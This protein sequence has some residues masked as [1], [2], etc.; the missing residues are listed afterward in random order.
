MFACAVGLGGATPLA[1]QT[2]SADVAIAK[3]G[4]LAADA[5][6][7]LVFQ[8]QATNLGPGVARGVV[9]Q[10]Q[11]PPELLFLSA[12]G[13]ATHSAGLVTWP[14]VDTLASGA[15]TTVFTVRVLALN[16]TPDRRVVNN[17]GL[18]STTTNDP[19]ASNDVVDVP[20]VV[21]GQLQIPPD[22]QVTLIAPDSVFSGDVFQYVIEVFNAGPG[23]E[24][25]VQVSHLLPAS[26]TLLGTTP[27]ATRN[28]NTLRWPQIDSIVAGDRRTFVIDVR[29]PN[30]ADTLTATSTATG[31]LGDSS[32]GDNTQT[33]ITRVVQPV[34]PVANLTVSKAGPDTVPSE[35]VA[36][37]RIVVSNPGG[38]TATD[39]VVRDVLP[40]NGTFRGASGGGRASG[41]VV[42]WDTIPTL[43]PMTSRTFTVDVIAPAG[44][45]VMVNQAT[46]SSATPESTLQDNTSR[47]TTEV[48][49]P[50][51]ADV[52]VMKSG[53]AMAQIGDTVE[54]R[55]EVDNAGPATATGVA[56]AD[57]LPAGARLIDAD[58]G[59]VIGSVVTW[60]LASLNANA[61]QAFMVR[62]A[63]DSV[64]AY[65]DVATVSAAEPD[66]NLANNVDSVTTRVPEGADMEVLVAIRS[67]GRLVNSATVGDSIEFEV[68]V[69]NLGPD[70]ALN[71]V[72]D[73]DTPDTPLESGGGG[74]ARS[75]IQVALGTVAPGGTWLDTF[76]LKLDTEGTYVGTGRV[77]SAT[78]DP[79]LSNNFATTSIT[80]VDTSSLSVVINKQASDSDAQVGDVVGYTVVAH[81]NGTAG[82]APLEL[83]DRPPAGFTYIPGTARIDGDPV[84][85]PT[86]TADGG[87]ILPLGP[88]SGGDTIRV[89]YRSRVGPDAVRSDGVNRAR[90][91]GPGIVS[92]EA[93]ARVRVRNLHDRG[94][95]IGTVFTDCGCGEP[96]VKAEG[97]VG[98]P[99]V[100]IYLQDGSWT[101][102]DSEGKYSFVDLSPRSWVV[103]VDVSTLPPGSRLVPATTR[104]AGE[105]RSVWVDLKRGELARADF[106]D[107]SGLKVV[108]DTAVA[109]RDAAHP[110]R[111]VASGRAPRVGANMPN[112][113]AGLRSPAPVIDWESMLRRGQAPIVEAS[114]RD[115]AQSLAVNDSTALVPGDSLPRLDF[116]AL[117]L[118]EARLDLRSLSL[119]DLGSVRVR[120][121]F[122][123]ALR[124]WSVDNA[125]EQT[126]VGTRASLFADGAVGSN[127]WLTLRLDSEHDR[128]SEL[129]RDIQPD[130]QY[131]VLGDASPQNFDAQA[132]GRLF[133]RYSRGAS[134]AQWG[135]FNTS[136]ADRGV[137]ETRSLGAYARTLNGWLQHFESDRL[138]V[139]AFASRDRFRQVIDELPSR[140]VSGPYAL[141]RREGLINSETVD[142]VTRDR[143][144]P[145]VIIRTERMQRFADYSIEPFTGRLLFRR[146][147][148]TTDD[149][150]N[151]I[152]IRVAYEVES[153]G[154]A[155]WTYGAGGQF[156]LFDSRGAAGSSSAS[157]GVALEVGGGFVRDE[158]PLVAFDLGSI[159]ATLAIGESTRVTSEFARTD[160]SSTR[161]GD[162][163]RVEVTHR[164]G[165]LEARAFW[166]RTD[167]LFANPSSS[168]RPARDEL[169]FLGSARVSSSTLLLG[170]LLRT[171]ELRTGDQRS[172]GRF[173][174]DRA[175]TDVIRAQLGFR[176]SRFDG[177]QLSDSSN[178]DALG[179]RLT[180]QPG[181]NSRVF[182]EFE[183]DVVDSDRRR[184]ALGGDYR[185]FGGNRLYGRYEFLD[186]LEGPYRAATGQS[187]SGTLF[188]IASDYRDGQSVFTEYRSRDAFG[189]R[190]AHAAIGLRNRWRIRDGVEVNGSAER[191]TPFDG[192]TPATA[193]TGA[194]ALTYDPL[195]KATARAEYYARD[196]VD[197]V[198]GSIGY[199][200]KLSRE[201]T[202]LGR[203]AFSVELGGGRAFERTQLGV[204]YRDV[205]RNLWNVLSRYEHRYDR[206]L[207]N[208]QKSTTSAHLLSTHVNVL[209]AE[210]ALVRGQWVTRLGDE[211]SEL[212]GF[213]FGGNSHLFGVRT[214]FD[215]AHYL[216]I[217][218]V[219]RTLLAGAAAADQYGL[220]FEI[221]T[222]L[223]ND[224]RL[225]A[226]YNAFGFSDDNNLTDDATD[227]G[228]YLQLGFKFDESLFGAR[229]TEAPR[230]A[231]VERCNCDTIPPRVDSADVRLSGSQT[232]ELERGD[233]V[234]VTLVWTITN[235]GPHDARGV[236]ITVD[237]P[238]GARW[239][240][241]GVSSGSRVSWSGLADL[242][243]GSE[244]DLTLVLAVDRCGWE[245]AAHG[246]AGSSTLDPNTTNN[247]TTVHV[248]TD[249]DCTPDVS[250][251]VEAPDSVVSG[252]EVEWTVTRRVSAGGNPAHD[253]VV[254]ATSTGAVVRADLEVDTT[255]T[256]VYELSWPSL[257]RVEPGA[258]TVE[259]LRT[260]T[261]VC[262]GRDQ[263]LDLGARVRA[264]NDADATNNSAQASVTVLCRPVATLS[265]TIL[266]PDTRPAYVDS[267]LAFELRTQN[268]GDTTA[269]NVEVRARLDRRY[270]FV[271]GWSGPSTAAVKAAGEDGRIDWPVRDSLAVGSWVVDTLRVR[272]TGAPRDFTIVDSVVFVSGPGTRMA[273]TSIMTPLLRDTTAPPRPD[274][275]D[276]AVFVRGPA[277]AAPGDTVSFD[278]VATNISADTAR[279]VELWVGRPDGIKYVESWL[280][281]PAGPGATASD[282]SGGR[283]GGG[284]GSVTSAQQGRMRI[285]GGDNRFDRVSWLPVT[286]LLPGD[287]LYGEVVLV[288]PPVVGLYRV[289]LTGK[290]SNTELI[291]ENNVSSD[292]VWTDTGLPDLALNLRWLA[293]TDTSAQFNVQVVNVGE[294]RARPVR[295]IVSLPAGGTFDH[296]P[297]ADSIVWT[298]DSLAPGQGAIDSL[299]WI[300]FTKD[301]HL[302]SVQARTETD[303][304]EVT[305]VNNQAPVPVIFQSGWP[306][307]LLLVALLIGCLVGYWIRWLNEPTPDPTPKPVPAPVGRQSA[308]KRR[309]TAFKLNR[310]GKRE[311]AEKIL[312]ELVEE[313]GWNSWNG[314]HLG[315]VF[316]DRFEDAWRAAPQ[317]AEAKALL[318]E[319]IET[320]RRGHAPG[321]PNP[322]PGL[323]ALTL[324]EF[325]GEVPNWKDL[326]LEEV[327]KALQGAIESQLEKASDQVIDKVVN[328]ALAPIQALR[329]YWTCAS[330]MEFGVLTGDRE[331]AE[332]GLESALVSPHVIPQAETT[333]R[334]LVLI[335]DAREAK[336]ETVPLWIVAILARMEEHCRSGSDVES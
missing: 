94:I 124:T 303:I 57:S 70:T 96:G 190:E 203:S 22:V 9:V 213:D 50:I 100:R 231:S 253:V 51:T 299:V 206:E 227:H 37:Y 317:S 187:R 239:V 162:A 276:I 77:T 24:E 189:G 265:L 73:I 113:F 210:G 5:G 177:T 54:Y 286:E 325:L 81:V 327:R 127:G 116:M 264:R 43:A 82:P 271:D 10:D 125:S 259:T 291:L 270:S 34:R 328:K 273:L 65:T 128:R 214:T 98:I 226:G 232:Q 181:E 130:E 245:G 106:V 280:D 173:A 188:G 72:V 52:S 221:G 191:L 315:R 8:L 46:V 211:T 91:Q 59:Q 169:G 168:Y 150:F 137:A 148:P 319:A 304:P 277:W 140:G 257:D 17:R 218:V 256:G 204:A 12:S 155:Y 263:V 120:D 185:L 197:N 167:S 262:Y 321:D 123:D 289:E 180:A 252:Q 117:G 166:L 78:Y 112:P 285:A 55:I 248:D 1:A 163:A 75:P 110:D 33:V 121:R 26:V 309:A 142:L 122:E 308:K 215:L 313:E 230:T 296:A 235:D 297:E 56:V 115:S 45:D 156:R 13:G 305:M 84:P 93:Q 195:W 260:R 249:V 63:F 281:V 131:S 234:H 209:P 182:A 251:L 244:A 201:F 157:R 287:S 108:V 31:G 333:L 246:D 40:S 135:D 105:G 60:N 199:A 146:P 138:Q 170:E 336:G 329:D 88:R 104:H 39:V 143:T 32:P 147:V 301:A 164:S 171:E 27:G 58:G 4:D 243:A 312:R 165:P 322:Y 172:G 269:Y 102:T 74:R 237:L 192:G 202:L 179:A 145:G 294:R 28:G 233:S 288:A 225:A 178:V 15:A 92:N 279:G 119:D 278:V 89:S 307:W 293:K 79:R 133:G 30:Q 298:V 107:G 149:N 267:V 323:N 53:P 275:T 261:T 266:G 331:E 295:V 14:A 16:S 61:G 194:L 318:D 160:S 154:D 3:T 200:R 268:T 6:D 141:S 207:L 29:A 183:Q 208:G 64:G 139:E 238:N 158:N 153:G 228:F 236:R 47:A 18:L 49:A 311:A 2:Q 66:P 310:A 7:T 198:L 174:L 83:V 111:D 132:K 274:T 129:F 134:F 95:I 101:Y 330:A 216:D 23:T 224:L 38:V 11:L 254:T 114:A 282:G 97:E 302:D 306:W 290:V 255:D 272:G 334:N 175:L 184:A 223:T 335:R 283:G 44:P 21:E 85:D 42:V 71:V 161:A 144:Q 68:V 205:D 247:D 126:A 222:V 326:L 284:G 25:D 109:R 20:V 176:F 212:D 300:S 159:N 118:V 152:S 80:T 62:V 69:E 48:L 219:G 332:S 320:Y 292:S 258:A 242:P 90:V 314:G 250:V 76:R 196:G 19:D 136:G 186:D 241:G 36:Q 324:S 99:G 67:G 316:K 35:G 220:G 41:G 87:W 193:L 217:G 86:P 229:R 103:A 151:P 240:E